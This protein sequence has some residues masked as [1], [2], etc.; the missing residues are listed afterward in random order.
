M[1]P[2]RI[3]ILGGGPAGAFAAAELA[4]AGREVILFDEKLVW[5]KP[6]GGGLTDKALARWPFLRDTQVEHNWISD[7]E[8]IA[9][10]GRKVALELDRPIAIFPRVALN[11]LLLDRSREAG[12]QV[13]RERITK[14]D[15]T[16]GN[17]RLQSSSGS[18]CADFLVLAAGARNPFRGQFCAPLGPEN[19]VVAVGF[20]I[21]GTSRLAQIKFLPGLHGYLWVFPRSDHFSAGICGRIT[22]KNTADLRRIL[23]KSLPEFG[24]THEGASFYAHIIPSF[25]P[26]TLQTARFSGDGWAM[27]G[28]AAGFVDGVTGEGLYYALR[29]AEL[30]SEAL[31]S[32][33][34]E[35]YAVLV[36]QDFLPELVRA[37]R[38]AD[39][40]YSGKWL[41]GNVIERMIVL[42]HRSPRFREL[43]RDLFAGTQEYCDL[44]QRVKRNLPRIAAEAL[45]SM[46]SRPMAEIG[47]QSVR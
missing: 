38:I 3:A 39:R 5:E 24:L 7:C 28:D 42:T 23:E 4:R 16:P 18:H 8:L 27:I 46:F 32:G 34:P 13:L 29:S 45:A 33:S 30:F 35:N 44:R 41:G 40:F 21:P 12:A 1:T 6:C 10:S 26:H 19:F 2:K 20:Y 25:T 37:A 43:M 9:P 17:W 11:G 15:G 31:L 47:R 22:G 14:I 36:K